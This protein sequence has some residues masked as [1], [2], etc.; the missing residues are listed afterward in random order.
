MMT[1]IRYFSTVKKSN[2]VLVLEDP[3]L[4]K[5]Q[6]QD[7]S[8]NNPLYHNDSREIVGSNSNNETEIKKSTTLSNI[9]D[10]EEKTIRHNPYIV[11]SAFGNKFDYN[12][13]WQRYQH[14]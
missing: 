4:S 13:E 8:Q 10:G 6:D 1:C 7:H 11:T 2:S 14:R 3:I 9:S 12:D 5:D